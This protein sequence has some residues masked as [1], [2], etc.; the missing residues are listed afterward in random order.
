MAYVIEY[1][2][3]VPVAQR[4]RRR[5]NW[6][7]IRAICFLMAAIAVRYFWGDVLTGILIPGEDDA[8]VEA[9]SNLLSALGE[10]ESVS[11]SVTA[12]CREVIYGAS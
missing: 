3:Q 1:G 2:G 5:K 11:E 8:T 12:F 4:I 6:K 10:G 9:F 7:W